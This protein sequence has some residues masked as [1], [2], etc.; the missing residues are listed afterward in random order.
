M[1]DERIDEIIVKIK[2]DDENAFRELFFILHQPVYRFIYRMINDSEISKDLTQDTFIRFWNSRKILDISQSP[3][4]YIYKIGKN[5]TLNH[6]QRNVKLSRLE[7]IKK[8][9]DYSVN[10]H[11]YDEYDNKELIKDLNNTL[12]LLPERCRMVFV[13]SRFNEMKYTEIAEVMGTSLQTVKNQMNKAL[14]LL[15]KHLDVHK[16]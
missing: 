8:V 15:R 6:I 5:L 13:L 4:A 9:S 2:Q 7:D 10:V 16:D 14:G 12:Q 3:T 11:L 1:N